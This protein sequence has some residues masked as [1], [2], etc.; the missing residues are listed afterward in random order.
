MTDILND[1][2]SKKAKKIMLDTDA[3]NEINDQFAISYVALSPNIELLSVNSALYD[4]GYGPES[5]V[6]RS[7]DEILQTLALAVPNE[8]IPVYK[9][10]RKKMSDPKYPVGSPAADNI[11]NT[12]LSSEE[13]VYVVAIG[14]ITNVVSAILKAP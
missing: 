10:A 11:I 7:Y 12:V 3:A 2:K 13:R 5:G 4:D 9:G 1:I 8:K 6:I 14:A